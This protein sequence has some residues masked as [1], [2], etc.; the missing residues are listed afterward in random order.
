MLIPPKLRTVIPYV[1]TK[2]SGESGIVLISQQIPYF[3]DIYQFS[4]CADH[5]EGPSFDSRSIFAHQTI[6]VNARTL[7]RFNMLRLPKLCADRQGGVIPPWEPNLIPTLGGNGLSARII[8][9]LPIVCRICTVMHEWILE[10][11]RL[12][13]TAAAA[14][15]L[16]GCASS[17][18]VKP[19]ATQS[20]FAQDRAVCDYQSEMGT[21]DI[22]GYNGRGG[23]NDAIASGI[24][25]GI[26]SGIRK[27][28]LMN[29][30]MVAHGWSLQRVEPAAN[31]ASPTKDWSDG[32]DAGVAD[33]HNC[34][35]AGKSD[36]WLQGCFKSLATNR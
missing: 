7:H 11:M 17:V 16:A 29:K 12:L 32:Y 26:A 2:T 3:I 10:M 36:L 13:T 28:T 23:M 24:A 35:T 6:I 18:W 21:P 34:D 14:L 9:A 1:I 15:L 19:G 8:F 31:D 25:D 22:N 5:G 27:G 4:D 20:D 30:C 33:S